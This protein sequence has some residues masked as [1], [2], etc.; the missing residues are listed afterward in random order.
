MEIPRLIAVT[1]IGA[2][3][4][5]FVVTASPEECAALAARMDIP[6]VRAMT[7]AFRLTRE[8]DGVSIAAKGELRA[9]VVRTCIVSAEDFE[10]AAVEDFEIRFVPA[11][12]ERGDL[13]PDQP[14]EVPYHGDSIDLGEAASQQ[15]GL[16]LDPYP[17]VP[18][19]ILPDIGDDANRSPF[20]ALTRRRKSD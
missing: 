17:R 20:A 13:D 15:L 10:V 2:G 6:A 16:A 7:C 1:K 12:Q 18:D 8:D 14:D 11:G 5:T 3:G 19:A 4:L 9:L